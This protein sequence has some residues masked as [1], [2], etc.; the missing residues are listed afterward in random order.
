M[1]TLLTMV[2]RL[3]LFSE[4]PD[5]LK[6]SLDQI[7]VQVQ[8]PELKRKTNMPIYWTIPSNLSIITVSYDFQE[9]PINWTL[10]LL[11][12]ETHIFTQYFDYKP[13]RLNGS[14]QTA[15]ILKWAHRKESLSGALY[16]V[17]IEQYV[18]PMTGIIP[19]RSD[20]YPFLSFPMKFLFGH[21]CILLHF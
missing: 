12:A 8:V 11:I 9:F 14:I 18:Q 17:D 16:P 7:L 15:L 1:N 20:P 21:F 10:Q 6:Q 13:K 4:V 19:G 3:C 5:S 2:Q